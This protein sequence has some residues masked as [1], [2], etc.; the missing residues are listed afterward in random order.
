MTRPSKTRLAPLAILLWLSAYGGGPDERDLGPGSRKKTSPTESWRT[1]QEKESTG[2]RVQSFGRIAWFEEAALE[3]QW[4]ADNH[5]RSHRAREAAEKVKRLR[6]RLTVLETWKAKRDVF[7]KETRARMGRPDALDEAA[8]AAAGLKKAPFPF[9]SEFAEKRLE[10]MRAAADR[11]VRKAVASL[12]RKVSAHA[13]KRNWPLAW[14]TFGSFDPDYRRI[15][16]DL[17]EGVDRLK[18][19]I[20]AKARKEAAGLMEKAEAK[21]EAGEVFTAVRL[22][23]RAR[24]RFR[25][26]PVGE[27]LSAKERDLRV[28]AGTRIIKDRKIRSKVAPPKPAPPPQNEGPPPLPGSEEEKVAHAMK[29][30]VVEEEVPKPEVLFESAADPLAEADRWYYKAVEREREVL[31]GDEGY[32]KNLEKTIVMYGKVR[33]L[34]VHLLEKNKKPDEA[35]EERIEKV[36]QALFWCKKNR[37]LTFD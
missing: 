3:Y 22:V 18:K 32:Q 12:R 20:A 28:R 8:R 37:G 27:A 29:S 15:F 30:P 23:A 11:T 17:C 6:K 10:K 31:P 1:A 26:L 14:E 24:G 33:K 36:N 13:A 19:E 5:P 21:A 9:V 7:D 4:L 2:D 35:I 16:P 34:Y 25:G